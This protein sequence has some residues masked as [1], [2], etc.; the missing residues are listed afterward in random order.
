MTRETKIEKRWGG[1]AI[2]AVSLPPSS[3]RVTE[4]SARPNAFV[5]VGVEHFDMFFLGFG[6]CFFEAFLFS[7][8]W[9]LGF[10]V[11]V[12]GFWFLVVNCFWD[13]GFWLTCSL[14]ENTS[15]PSSARYGITCRLAFV[16]G[17]GDLGFGLGFRVEN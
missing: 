15:V 4:N 1:E 3:V 14:S 10:W 7:G 13:F 12:L 2:P 9:F 6:I 8:I 5:W 16:F 17:F 11:L